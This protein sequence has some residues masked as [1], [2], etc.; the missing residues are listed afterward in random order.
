MDQVFC[1]VGGADWHLDMFDARGRSVMDRTLLSARNDAAGMRDDLR[2]AML[3]VGSR[4]TTMLSMEQH[5]D[6]FDRL[7]AATL[8]TVMQKMRSEHREQRNKLRM[9]MMRRRGVCV[10]Q[11]HTA[12][13]MG[14]VEAGLRALE[15]SRGRVPPPPPPESTV[16]AYTTATPSEDHTQCL[17]D[18]LIDMFA[19]QRQIMAL[20]GPVAQKIASLTAAGK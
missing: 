7:A 16:S 17:Q 3:E 14:R 2:S 15:R 1:G 19:Q 13:H 20:L 9:A 4:H 6:S 11:P 8:D 10:P 18:L 12:D 5:I